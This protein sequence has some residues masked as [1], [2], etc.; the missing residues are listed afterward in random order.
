VARARD[1]GLAVVAALPYHYPR[2]LL[3][4]HRCHAVE[5]WAPTS[6]PPDR[7]A[8]HFQAYTCGIVV[9]GTAFLVEQGFDRVDAVLVPH[10]CDALQGMGSVLGDFVQP[11]PPVLTY[12]PPR[13][14][15]AVDREYLVREMAGLAERLAA[16]TGH[17]PD[18]ADWAAALAAEEAA[19]AALAGLYAR[20]DR[21]AL[22]DREFYTAVRSREYLLAEDFVALVARLPEGSP[23]RPGIPL[24][25]SGIVAEPLALLDGVNE[26]GA[27]VV[28]DDL[29]CGWRRVLP[30]SAAPDP[31]QRLAERFMAGPPDP[32]RADPVDVRVTSLVERL[33]AAHARG[34]VVYDVK[35]CEPELFYVPLLR[36]RLAAAGFPVLHVEVEVTDDVPSQTLTR[37]EAFVETLT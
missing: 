30:P 32:T 15:R 28:A 22:S 25:L 17:R 9:R 19:D 7:G 23:P 10:G 16:L 11:R 8:R 13:S 12:Y 5:V 21:L 3:R 29:S 4:A 14:R 20:R 33:T 36:E 24:M 18:D 1:R 37:I 27:H 35:F 31:Y 34:L 2:A 6:V 26:V